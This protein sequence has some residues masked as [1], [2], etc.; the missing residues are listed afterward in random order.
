MPA[1][2]ATS[3]SLPHHMHSRTIDCLHTLIYA[4]QQILLWLSVYKSMTDGQTNREAYNYT[5][6]IGIPYTIGER[7]LTEL[8]QS[9][10][11]HVYMHIHI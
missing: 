2:Q 4:Q 7:A 1:I 3:P 6:H 9:M 10:H 5:Y 8:L 11:A